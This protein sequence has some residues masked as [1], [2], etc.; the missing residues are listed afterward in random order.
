MKSGTKIAFAIVAGM[1]LGAAAVQVLHAQDKAKPQVIQISE[2]DVSNTDAYL[3]EYAP[4]TQANI[5]KAGGRF[6]A[7]GGKVTSFEG[8]PAKGRVAVI[9]WDSAEKY[10]AYRDSKDNKDMRKIGDKYA[11]FRIYTVE[12]LA[13]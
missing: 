3:K 7:A 2:I 6:L 8:Q 1:G 13:K 5:K 9:V 11:K 4:K 12:A 10:Q